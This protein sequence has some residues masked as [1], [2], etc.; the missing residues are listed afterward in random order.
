MPHSKSC[1][2]FDGDDRLCAQATLF[3]ALHQQ[4]TPG[5]FSPPGMPSFSSFR[6]RVMI[7]ESILV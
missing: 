7:I 1:A 3:N 2:L 6:L 4:K 5:T